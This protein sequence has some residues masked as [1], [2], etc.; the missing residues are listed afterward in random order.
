MENNRTDLWINIPAK[1]A[2]TAKSGMFRTGLQ[3][4]EEISFLSG[5][6]RDV[7]LF[8]T[9]DMHLRA[10]RVS[11]DLDAQY[12]D[13]TMFVESS[14]SSS[15]QPRSSGETGMLTQAWN[16]QISLNKNIGVAPL[17]SDGLWDNINMEATS[18]ARIIGAAN[19]PA[20][21]GIK[22]FLI[23][24]LQ[25]AGS[26]ALSASSDGLKSGSLRLESTATKGECSASIAGGLMPTA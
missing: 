25:T 7:Y 13:A 20:E 16:H 3:A 1:F 24:S 14:M 19:G 22:G 5:I 15:R 23:Q 8:S 12:E 18:A 4:K 26:I 10:F 9:A 21:N 6:Y 11:S 17:A 2:S